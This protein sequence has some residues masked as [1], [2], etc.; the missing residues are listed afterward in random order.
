MTQR[1]LHTHTQALFHTHTHT[2]TRTFLR[3]DTFRLSSLRIDTITNRGAFTNRFL[4]RNFIYGY[5]SKAYFCMIPD[6]GHI[7]RTTSGLQAYIKPQFHSSLWQLN[8]F[9]GKGWPSASPHCNFTSKKS[10]CSA[11]LK[12][13]I[14]K[15]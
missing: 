15:K 2:Q 8:T 10:R 12:K 11:A 13:K 1:W 14:E 9:R 3:R 6:G 7:F 4:T 5:F